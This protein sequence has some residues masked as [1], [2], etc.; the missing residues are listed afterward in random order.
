MSRH[1][2]VPWLVAAVFLSGCKSSHQ[3]GVDPAAID[4]S[5]AVEDWLCSAQE[6]C[7]NWLDRH[8][9][10][11]NAAM[12]VGTVVVIVGVTALVLWAYSHQET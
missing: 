2:L 8:P 4:C 10:V 11:K 1:C 3:G 5:P 12:I 7:E 6:K 9:V